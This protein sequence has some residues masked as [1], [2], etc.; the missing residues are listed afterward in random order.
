MFLVEGKTLWA[1][2]LLC[3]ILTAPAFAAGMQTEINHLLQFVEQTDCQYER[4]GKI[5]SGKEAAEHIK[6][7]YNY[8]KDDIDSAEKFIELSATKSTI[9]GKYYLVHCPNHLTI[10]SQEWLLQEL[11][12]FREKGP[13]VR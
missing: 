10:R 5:H 1:T 6:K 11:D 8:F 4:N 13:L 7:K 9:S 2:T 12:N 3:A